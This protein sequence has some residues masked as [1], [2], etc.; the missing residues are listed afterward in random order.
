MMKQDKL[1]HN[2]SNNNFIVYRFCACTVPS[3]DMTTLIQ[4]IVHQ[5]CYFLEIHE[6]WSFDSPHNIVDNL[7]KALE[8]RKSLDDAAIYKEENDFS[9]KQL[10]ILLDN[11][12]H[13]IKSKNDHEM[14]IS[15]IKNL[16]NTESSLCY[17]IR[18]VLTYSQLPL[19]YKNHILELEQLFTDSTNRFDSDSL[20][21]NDPIVHVTDKLESIFQGN[22]EDAALHVQLLHGLIILLKRSR[23]GYKQSEIIELLKQLASNN[24][25]NNSQ[26]NTNFV[27]LSVWFTL[28][29]SRNLLEGP[30]LIQVCVDNSHVLYRLIPS[31]QTHTDDKKLNKLVRNFYEK[32]LTPLPLTFGESATTNA[33]LRAFEEL[34]NCLNANNYLAMFVLNDQWL[35]N[36]CLTSKNILYLMHDIEGANIVQNSDIKY[37]YFKQIFYKNLY[38]LHQDSRQLHSKFALYATEESP[39]LFKSLES[40]TAR[41]VALNYKDIL[42]NTVDNIESKR[43]NIVFNCIDPLIHYSKVFFIGQKLVLAISQAQ[44]EIKIWKLN[45][46]E[47]TTLS[48]T[49]TIRL[50]KSPKD[51]RLLN[52]H[53][54]VVLVDRNLHIFDLNLCKH[55]LDLKSTMNTSFPFFQVHDRNHV[56]LLGRNRLSVILMKVNVPTDTVTSRDE[57]AE[58]DGRENPLTCEKETIAALAKA[59]TT[60]TYSAEDDMFLFKVGED[61]FLNSLLVSKNGQIMVCGDEVQK[62]FPLLVWNLNQRKL[63]YD[64]RQYKHEFIT[65]IQ[66]IGSSGK[67]MVCGS[68]VRYAYSTSTVT[69]SY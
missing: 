32:A 60:K 56:V 44:N 13:V 62:P 12:D 54:A 37:E 35:I 65:S 68:K 69:A 21:A 40:D 10:L 66:A 8:K 49:R 52:D 42:Y 27:V 16:Y 64:L 55:V 30:E 50:N 6:S 61:R 26:L 48:L 14:L 9:N 31:L 33:K 53:I 20:P 5:I 2:V 4:S 46:S 25:S 34:P 39:E 28:K 29:N 43:Q 57:I 51:M 17:N 47:A 18:I 36:K 19:G 1:H 24:S 7:F 15:L 59:V 23:Y 63:V 38:A 11:V 58:S 67:F 45:T 22:Y 3:S 41:L